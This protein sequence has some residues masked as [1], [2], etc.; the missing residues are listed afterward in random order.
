M[1]FQQYTGPVTAKGFEDTSLYRYNRLISLNDVG[2]DPRRLG[3]SPAALHHLTQERMR[4]WPFSML[5]TST[6]DKRRGEDARGRP[7]VT[8][9]VP[10]DGRGQV[11]RRC[12]RNRRR[13]RP[14]DA[15][16]ATNGN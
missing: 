9:S 14:A 1:K 6:N 12:R 8:A 10:R 7:H 16:G 2:G 13:K 4:R 3:L 5:S 15:R 11:R